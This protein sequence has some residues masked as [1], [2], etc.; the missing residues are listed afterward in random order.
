VSTRINEGYKEKISSLIIGGS[1]DTF[2]KILRSD[3]LDQKLREMIHPIIMKNDDEKVLFEEAMKIT[4]TK[5]EHPKY[6][7]FLDMVTKGHAD[8]FMNGDKSVRKY[9]ENGLAEYLLIHSDLKTDIGEGKGCTKIMV[10]DNTFLRNYGGIACITWYPISQL[11]D[12][13]ENEG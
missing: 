9:L 11:L 1:S 2:H 3:D 12:E 7:E 4:L 5:T 6:L 8:R 13:D 10:Y